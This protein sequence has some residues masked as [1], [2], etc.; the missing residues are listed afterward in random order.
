[1]NNNLLFSIAILS[2]S[3]T[4]SSLSMDSTKPVD[5]SQP[6]DLTRVKAVF[7]LR[8]SCEGSSFEKFYAKIGEEKSASGEPT[9]TVTLEAIRYVTGDNANTTKAYIVKTTPVDTDEGRVIKSART[10]TKSYYFEILQEKIS[11]NHKFQNV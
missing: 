3:I 5:Y 10:S 7:S 4:N 9:T 11:Q 8:G 1:M 6:L 2:L